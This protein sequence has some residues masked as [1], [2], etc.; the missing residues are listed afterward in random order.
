MTQPDGTPGI[1]EQT[2]FMVTN[3]VSSQMTR[4]QRLVFFD[5]YQRLIKDDPVTV[6]QGYETKQNNYQPQHTT[7]LEWQ[8]V[9]GN[10]LVA[11]LQVS[12]WRVHVTQNIRGTGPEKNDIGIPYTSGTNAGAGNVVDHYRPW[13]T[14]G[15]VS[16]FRPDLFMG[17]HDFKAGY[18]D[19]KTTSGRGWDSRVGT[20]A[21]GDYGLRFNNNVPIEILLYNAPNYPLT[22]VHSTALY[23][24]DKWSVGRRL[25]LNLGFRW[26][27]DDGYIPAQCRDAGTF[28]PAN[29]TDHIQGATQRSLV[30]RLYATY[31]LTGDGKTAL[32]GGWG[33]FADWRNGNHVLPLNPNV[34]LQRRY[35]WTDPNGNGD[36]DEGEVNLTVG[37]DFIEE[38]GRGNVTI[39]NVESNP[40]QPQTKEDQF[41]LSLER[42]LRANFAVRVTGLYSRRFDVIRSQNLRRGPEVY[43]IANTR[44]DPGPD[45]RVGTGDD[46]GTTLTWWEYP[47]SL[48]PSLLPVE[49]TGWRPGRHRDLQDSRAHGAEAALQRMADAG[50]LFGDEG[51]HPGAR[52]EQH[53][54][55]R[56]HQ[57]QQSDVGVAV[58]CVER[59][60][61]PARRDVV[62]EL[63]APER[64]RAGANSEP[65][66]WWDHPDDYAECRADRQPS[67]AAPQHDGP[68]GLEAIRPGQRAANRGTDQSLQRLQRQHGDARTVLSGA[69]YLRPTAIMPARILDFNIA[70]SF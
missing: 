13:A 20:V 61:V 54:S 41:S 14:R 68:P 5:Y 10:S 38:V 24:A 40:D 37:T 21:K 16:W 7:K 58:S 26:A 32:K 8:G 42:E 51:R 52:R 25:T 11:S 35:R 65:Q 63:R 59:L 44:P 27:R 60:R 4:S 19:V 53:Q 1:V 15:S 47:S 9:K 31:D 28:F 33:R 70:Y 17:S 2:Q 23:F 50:V 46:P 18:D 66:W 22:T 30:P 3:K 29:C 55:E 43:T 69:N 64:R 49:Y 39:A 56:R 48:Q 36:Y 67:L 57:Q 62:G 6:Q 45:G 12:R 34:A